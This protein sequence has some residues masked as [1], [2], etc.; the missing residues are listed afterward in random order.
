MSEINELIARN[1]HLAYEHG[2]IAERRIAVEILRQLPKQFVRKDEVE[3][4][5]RVAIKKLEEQ[6]DN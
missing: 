5:V 6:P 1:A 4:A 3:R 2:R